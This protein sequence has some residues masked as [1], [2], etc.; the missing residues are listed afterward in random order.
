MILAVSI[1][2]WFLASYPAGGERVAGLEARLA[3]VSGAGQDVEVVR[4]RNEIA[5]VSLR[6]SFAGRVGRFLEPAI[7]PR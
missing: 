7:R 5:A 1:V 4:I 2:L 3:E 6:E